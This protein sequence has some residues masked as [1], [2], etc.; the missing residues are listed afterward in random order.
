MLQELEASSAKA[1]SFALETTLAVL[2]YLQHIRLW[3]AQ[4]Y[5]ISLFFLA[6][7]T[8]E[9]AI[10][11]VA[12]RVRQGGHSIP[13][14]VI[15]RRFVAGFQNFLEHYQSAVNAWV[16]YDNSGYMPPV[17]NWGRE[18]MSAQDIA[19]ARDPDLRAS[20]DALKRAAQQARRVAVQTNTGI[21]IVRNDQ[22]IHISARE[23]RQ[24]KA[25]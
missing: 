15:R 7:P 16:H 20:L 25:E 18:Q 21:V 3:K 5:R 1:E 24:S 9:R 17:L 6:F 14:A 10:P 23:L 8:A 22:L 4:G 19:N 11:R 13:E 12:E 2:S